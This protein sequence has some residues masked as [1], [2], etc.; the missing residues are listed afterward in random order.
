[1][2]GFATSSVQA[3][4][5]TDR[6]PKLC[7]PGPPINGERAN[8]PP[9][10]VSHAMEFWPSRAQHISRWAWCWL[11][12]VPAQASQSSS[13]LGRADSFSLSLPF[14][15]Y[16][17]INKLKTMYRWPASLCSMTTRIITICPLW[18]GIFRLRPR[19]SLAFG[20][21]VR[22]KIPHPVSDCTAPTVASP[23]RVNH[24]KCTSIPAIIFVFN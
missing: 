1:M 23:F 8:A 16:N 13:G 20:Q 12:S 2:P 24:S 18:T 17:T 10:P 22:S 5:V 21:K 9:D 19:R 3:R 11:G 4:Y 15:S 14:S 7:Q 6:T